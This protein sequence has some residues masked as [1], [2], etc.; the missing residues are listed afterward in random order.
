MLSLGVRGGLTG[1][2]APDVHQLNAHALRVSGKCARQRFCTF[3]TK[4]STEENM[5][6]QQR[7]QLENLLTLSDTAEP[8]ACCHHHRAGRSIPE[9]GAV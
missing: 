7:K 3:V 9:R 8:G 1:R 5:L 2:L 6:W 4:A